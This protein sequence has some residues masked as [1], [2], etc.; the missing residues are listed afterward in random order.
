[1][2]LTNAV[3]ISFYRQTSIKQGKIII[4]S[5]LFSPL[6]E[7]LNIRKKKAGLYLKI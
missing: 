3:F 4:V 5:I 7:N 2:V 6:L 1:M